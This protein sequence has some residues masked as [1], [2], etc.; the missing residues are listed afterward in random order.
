MAV[1]EAPRSGREETA[2]ERGRYVVRT[3]WITQAALVNVGMIVLCIYLVSTLIGIGAN[4]TAS[5]I[6]IV[7]LVTAIPLLAILSL[8]IELQRARR[9]AS[10]PWYLT[11]A[12]SV[13]QGAAVVGFGAAL[14]H[15]WFVATI[16]LVA[17]GLAGLIVF[18]AY[19]RRL[20]KDN[21]PDRERRRKA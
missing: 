6:A 17:S 3:E 13:G 12:G 1:P 2:D 9:Y 20:D 16:A 19:Y 5:R 15:V 7:A 21:T 18:Q 14:W 10:N 4:D 11:L 8:I